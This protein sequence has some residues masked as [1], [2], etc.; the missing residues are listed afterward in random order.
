MN[1]YVVAKHLH[2]TCVA[3]SIVGFI[4]RFVLA[5]RGSA[6]VRHSFARIAPHINDTLLL[7]AAISML[8]IANIDPLSLAWLR[9]KIIG[10]VA[11][12]ALG[13]VALR[14]GRTPLM[15][16]LAFAL[17]LLTFGFVVV[18]AITKSPCGPAGP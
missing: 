1:W 13:M 2:V 8:F 3:L 17:A 6:L 16:G 9:A 7:V 5:S 4:A 15:R 12:V 18:V 14:H 11:Y 10:L